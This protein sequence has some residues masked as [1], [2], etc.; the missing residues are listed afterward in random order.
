MPWQL[1]GWIGN[2]ILVLGL[3]LVGNKKR[4]CFLYTVVGETIWSAYAVHN[5]QWDL[6]TICALFAMLALRNFIKWGKKSGSSN[7]RTTE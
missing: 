6:A 1:M 2:V 4:S 3:W 5:Q 7:E